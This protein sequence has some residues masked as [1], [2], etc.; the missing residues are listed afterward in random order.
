VCIERNSMSRKYMSPSLRL[1]VNE[2]LLA[3]PTDRPNSELRPMSLPLVGFV[4]R[5][6]AWTKD[7]KHC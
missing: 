3:E 4:A 6:D 1:S 2:T 5:N 7:E